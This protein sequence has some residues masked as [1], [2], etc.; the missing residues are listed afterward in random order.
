MATFLLRRTLWQK[1]LNLNKKLAET[2]LVVKEAERLTQTTKELTDIAGSLGPMTA[3]TIATVEAKLP[4]VAQIPDIKK[5]MESMT[6]PQVAN[7]LPQLQDSIQNL[8][9]WAMKEL[10]PEIDAILLTIAEDMDK[11]LQFSGEATNAEMAEMYPGK[12]V[13]SQEAISNML[14]TRCSLAV[15][16][17]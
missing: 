3:E 16:R 12:P 7:T 13:G 8:K 15:S 17:R 6:T 11:Q 14:R 5:K 1:V 10:C 9:S 4:L 2:S